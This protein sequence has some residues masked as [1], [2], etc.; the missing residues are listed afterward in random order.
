MHQHW[1]CYYGVSQNFQS[2]DNEEGVPNS[3]S[4]QHITLDPIVQDKIQFMG[5][6]PGPVIDLLVKE[7]LLKY[8]HSIVLSRSVLAISS[9]SSV[10]CST[11]SLMH[12]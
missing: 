10:L 6:E 3:T 2:V 9:Y 7:K 8:I 11:T 5:C 12:L 1:Q 4:N